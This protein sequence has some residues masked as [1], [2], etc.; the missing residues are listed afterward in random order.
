VSS[1]FTS[2]PRAQ[3]TGDKNPYIDLEDVL[4]LL[5]V[6][7]SAVRLLITLG[8]RSAWWEAAERLPNGQVL[9]EVKAKRSVG[10]RIGQ[11]IRSTEK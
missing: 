7:D 1:I 3:D 10:N 11:P 6:G 4:R 2:L 8:A 5:I 9:L